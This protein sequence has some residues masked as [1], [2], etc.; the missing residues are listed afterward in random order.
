M[1]DILLYFLIKKLPKLVLD[2]I[3]IKV[4]INFTCFVFCE[5]FLTLLQYTS[6]F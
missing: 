6:I 1:Q 2:I 3:W 4:Y 5:D